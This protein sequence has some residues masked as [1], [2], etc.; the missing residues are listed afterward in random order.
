MINR[1]VS[2][3]ASNICAVTYAFTSIPFI[4]GDLEIWRSN[5]SLG[6][7]ILFLLNFVDAFQK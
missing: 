4:S 7:F 1:L 3:F 2:V 5:I 6:G